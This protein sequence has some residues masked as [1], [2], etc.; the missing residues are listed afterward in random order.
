MCLYKEDL[1]VIKYSGALQE[2]KSLKSTVS[3]QVNINFFL[4]YS[5]RLCCCFNIYVHLQTKADAEIDHFIK[6]RDVLIWKI[7]PVK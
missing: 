6:A 1:T 4:T 3:E 5:P 2:Q 7:I